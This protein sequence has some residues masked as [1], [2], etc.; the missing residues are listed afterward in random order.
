MSEGTELWWLAWDAHV[1]GDDAAFCKVVARLFADSGPRYAPVKI[2]DLPESHEFLRK[3][4]RV[5]LFASSGVPGRYLR[6]LVVNR[7]TYKK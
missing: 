3:I 2:L 5:R 6:P 1:A 7:I 4:S